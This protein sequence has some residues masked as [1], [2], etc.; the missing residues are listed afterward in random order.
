[1]HVR[2]ACHRCRAGP[3]VCL[4]FKQK[5]GEQGMA[6]TVFMPLFR[7]LGE[8]FSIFPAAGTD[9]CIYS[10]NPSH[11]LRDT[12]SLFSIGR[13][14]QMFVSWPCL[15]TPDV[16]LGTKSWGKY[17]PSIPY[18]NAI[19]LSFYPIKPE[20]WGEIIIPCEMPEYVRSSPW[21]R[22]TKLMDRLETHDPL[23]QLCRLREMR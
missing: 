3:L 8:I 18:G 20:R 17:L 10:A 5:V 2:D 14:L 9:L 4:R 13:S 6:L 22:P 12:R 15:L 1:M 21:I 19:I 16:M 23:R 11:V 7:D